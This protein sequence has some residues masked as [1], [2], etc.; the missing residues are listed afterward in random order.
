MLQTPTALPRQSIERNGG[1]ADLYLFLRKLGALL[2]SIAFPV[3]TY[4][5]AQKRTSS[6]SSLSIRILKNYFPEILRHVLE[7]LSNKEI[8]SEL[9]TSVSS[10]KATLQQLFN[11]TGIRTRSQ[12]VC[13]EK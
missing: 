6:L 11:K 4:F 2:S 12:L 3:S 10:V 8:G 7:G 1:S 5:L 13:G 9:L